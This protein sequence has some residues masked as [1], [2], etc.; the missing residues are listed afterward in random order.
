MRPG[1]VA[2]A[3]GINLGVCSGSDTPNQADQGI[4]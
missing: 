1:E 2:D 4:E 3:L